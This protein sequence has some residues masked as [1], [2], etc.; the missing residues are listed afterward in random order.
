MTLADFFAEKPL[1]REL[2]A[3]VRREV[4]AIGDTSVRVTNSQVAF[5]RRRT[6][7]SVWAPDLY[8]TGRDGLAP[9][10]LTIYL[11]RRDDSPR[12]KQVV[13]PASGRFTHHLE[14][15]DKGQVDPE[16]ESWLREAWEGA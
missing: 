13:Q 16:V 3:A 2:F 14:L 4:K 1:A 12:W 8:L 11:R 10:V 7:A 6:F 15:R 5:R 9:L